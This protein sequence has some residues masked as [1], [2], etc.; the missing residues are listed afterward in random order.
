MR[1]GPVLL[2]NSAPSLG[3][4]DEG[5]EMPRSGHP[6]NVTYF[7]SAKNQNHGQF[8][9]L[10]TLV[11]IRRCARKEL[12]TIC[13]SLTGWN[14]STLAVVA[15]GSDNLFT[16]GTSEA[17]LQKRVV[18]WHLGWNCMYGISKAMASGS[19][20][21][22]LHLAWCSYQ[23]SSRLIKC[24]KRW[25]HGTRHWKSS[26]SWWVAVW[27]WGFSAIGRSRWAYDRQPSG[28][29]HEN[30]L[31]YFKRF[32]MFFQIAPLFLLSRC[33]WP[34]KRIRWARLAQCLWSCGVR[35]VSWDFALSGGKQADDISDSDLKSE[36]SS[37]T[38]SAAKKAAAN[39]PN[40][41][42][43]PWTF[44]HFH[45]ILVTLISTGRYTA[46][47]DLHRVRWDLMRWNVVPKPEHRNMPAYPSATFLRKSLW[48]CACSKLNTSVVLRLFYILLSGCE[49]LAQLFWNVSMSTL[50]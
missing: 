30:D 27:S 23:D 35:L 12:N 31:T 36:A 3:F 1:P 4:P 38:Q 21:L 42:P 15:G 6:K 9:F 14:S 43:R 50:I 13:G 18:F 24:V 41:A 16:R 37:A 39:T 11:A 20:P 8:F 29:R 45:S 19:R 28:A 47:V 17:S 22:C 46:G 2:W 10:P 5:I 49:V 26:I 44:L 32:A 34:T 25:T 7:Q 40:A 48:N 33:G